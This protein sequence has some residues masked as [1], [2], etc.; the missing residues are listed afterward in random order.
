M[1]DMG[2]CENR[3]QGRGFRA[4]V[5]NVG[6]DCRNWGYGGEGE[7]GDR[8]TRVK[9]IEETIVKFY[10]M[11]ME[12]GEEGEDEGENGEVAV[13]LS[14]PSSLIALFFVHWHTFW[15]PSLSLP[16]SLSLSYSFSHFPTLNYSLCSLSL[17][18]PLPYISLYIVSPFLSSCTFSLSTFYSSLFP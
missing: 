3:D 7:D 1:V 11:N 6:K 8:V 5:E 10:V 4:K 15:I 16:L 14:W 2:T 13:R 9:V 12:R 17:S 18:P